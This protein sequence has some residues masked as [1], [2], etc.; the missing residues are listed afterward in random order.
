M[1]I[2]NEKT[3]DKSHADEKKLVPKKRSGIKEKHGNLSHDS[4]SKHD[5]LKSTT[6]FPRNALKTRRVPK[7]R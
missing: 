3:K 6:Q 4:L 7:K 2:E 1:F 5:R